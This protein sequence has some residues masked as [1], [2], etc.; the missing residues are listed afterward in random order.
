MHCRMYE[1]SLFLEVVLQVVGEG[2]GS[3]QCFEMAASSSS[4]LPH[5]PPLNLWLNQ[6]SKGGGC[7]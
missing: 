5:L 4:L 1:V 2:A 7:I 6:Y 3:P